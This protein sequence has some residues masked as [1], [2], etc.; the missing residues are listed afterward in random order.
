MSG[1]SNG[2]DSHVQLT[3]TPKLVQGEF[4]GG[5]ADSFLKNK[6]PEINSSFSSR[7]RN[8]SD[9]G[10]LP[11]P[12]ST[13]FHSPIRS[14]KSPGPDSVLKIQKRRIN[15]DNDNNNVV[16]SS[17]VMSKSRAEDILNEDISKLGTY[18]NLDSSHNIKGRMLSEYIPSDMIPEGGV[19]AAVQRSMS[20]NSQTVEKPSLRKETVI[21]EAI[22]PDYS[23]VEDEPEKEGD[24]IKGF[25]T[26]SPTRASFHWRKIKEI[27]SG[28]FSTVYLYECIDRNLD[29]G[30]NPE[31]RHVAV[32]SIKYPQE[33]LMSSSPSS[34]KYKEL[35]SRVE[36]SLKRELTTLIS[37]NHPCI[38]KL[39]AIND[40]SFITESN[41]LYG[42][43]KLST[44]PRCDMI[45]S[46]CPGGDLFELA[47]KSKIP[48]WLFPRIIAELSV[49]IKF[50]HENLVIHRDVKLENVLLKYTLDDMLKLR[51]DE[52]LYNS[53]NLVELAD[54]GLCKK[55]TA[56]EM[57]TTRCGS[58]DY[59]SPEILLGLPYDGRI[60]DAWAFGVIMYALLEDR[61]PFD[62]LPGQNSRR[63]RSIAHRIARC[64]WKWLKMAEVD[65]PAKEIVNNALVR[66]SERWNMTQ[67]CNSPYIKSVI[68]QLQFLVHND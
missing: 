38:V 45:M 31:L 15:N 23:S 68:D 3:E 8:V 22:A 6:I 16:P 1:T 34:P 67:I 26:N 7:D 11:T 36:S 2:G 64:D 33:L 25:M 9:M 50:L 24:V 56:D 41:P 27:G 29:A 43:R 52:R 54:F 49:A 19:A 60:S 48:D 46:Y 20:L 14:N 44:L 66:K 63:T 65:H 21:N 39:F 37:L 47:S 57:C 59:V 35:L 30:L 42:R 10:M 55:I 18:T 53:T 58:E 5:D 32:K 62:P 17:T 40:T 4:V 28:N 61:L 13:V 51:Q 12:T